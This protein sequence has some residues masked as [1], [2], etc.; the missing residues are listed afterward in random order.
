MTRPTKFVLIAYAALSCAFAVALGLGY[1]ADHGV[2]PNWRDALCNA[3]M[4]R[5][6]RAAE[7]Y[8]A[9]QGKAADSL[10]ELVGKG[11]LKGM[12]SNLHGDGHEYDFTILGGKAHC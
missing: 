1:L 8:L 7:T 2:Y 12:P 11:Y 10:D 9:D 5:I 4:R 6:G 3:Q